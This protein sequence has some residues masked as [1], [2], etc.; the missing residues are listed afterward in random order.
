MDKTEDICLET[1]V[2]C[3]RG[4]GEDCGVDERLS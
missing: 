2:G 4:N 3:G 1:S